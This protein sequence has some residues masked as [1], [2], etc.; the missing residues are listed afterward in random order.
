MG[1]SDASSGG[2]RGR[3][4]VAGLVL[5]VGVVLGTAACRVTTD[6]AI[7]VA[8]DGGGTVAV[9]LG[10]DDDALARV[11]EIDT[12]LRLDDLRATG[13]EISGPDR[14]ED[15]VTRFT[16]SKSFATPAEAATVMAEIATPGGPFRDLRLTSQRSFARTTFGFDGTVDLRGGLESFGDQ[17]LARLLD[18]EPLGADQAAI[19]AALGTPLDEAFRLRVEVAL[20]GSVSSGPPGEGDDSLVWEPSL[21]DSEPTVLNARSTAWRARTLLFTAAAVVAAAALGVLVLSRLVGRRRGRRAR[22]TPAGP[23]RTGP[24]R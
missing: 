10:L 8:E 15:G 21:A 3:G 2:R 5:V 22:R 9:S 7:D 4:L 18:G 11:P 13:W 23:P 6:V 19:E 14:G 16:A 24:R 1:R 12:E 17:E 20:P